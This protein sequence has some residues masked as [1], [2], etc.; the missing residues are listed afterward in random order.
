[1]PITPESVPEEEKEEA[2]RPGQP[3]PEVETP[4]Q[5]LEG[6][7]LKLAEHE[8]SIGSLTKERDNLKG[9]VET[10][11]KTVDEIKKSAA[12]YGPIRPDL[13]AAARKLFTHYE[14][15]VKGV[16]ANLGVKKLKVLEAV[17]TVE[18]AIRKQKDEVVPAAEERASKAAREADE[19]R[20][21]AE[22]AQKKYDAVKALP[23]T[24]GDNVKKLKDLEDKA[25]A[26][27]RQTKSASEYVVLLEQ[28][29]LFAETLV[30]TPEVGDEEHLPTPEQ[31]A[32]MLSDAARELDAARVD[33]R[34]KRQAADAAAAEL[35]K[36]Q[37][38]LKALDDNRVADTL[39][40]VE[41]LN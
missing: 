31:Y 8:S 34:N 12:A 5:V 6:L 37:A 29:K 18:A 20:A 28:K 21:K 17:G 36:E 11:S 19:A 38:A 10:L 15:E 16:E 1:M 32:K 3:T 24:L 9:N 39:K 27:D 26:F 33:E 35:K 40:A 7:K 22:R 23:K 14:A 2:V 41:P 30:H 25:E 13:D 4:E